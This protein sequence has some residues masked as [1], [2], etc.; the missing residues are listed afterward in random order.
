MTD[1][2]PRPCA[3]CGETIHRQAPGGRRRLYCKQSCRQ[4]AFEARRTAALIAEAVTAA[5]DS[6]RGLSPAE[7]AAYPPLP[8]GRK[9]RRQ[10]EVEP[11][12][13]ALF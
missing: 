5:T 10:A 12:P 13:L 6:S 7:A 8:R 11:G 2:T 3:W 4:R 9:R 1:T